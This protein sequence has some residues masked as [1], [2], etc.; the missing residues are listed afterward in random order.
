MGLFSFFNFHTFLSLHILFGL[1]SPLNWDLL[2]IGGKR[3]NGVFLG[4]V[5]GSNYIYKWNNKCTRPRLANTKIFQ[6]CITKLYCRIAKEFGEPQPLSP[7][8]TVG[9]TKFGDV[10]LEFCD[11]LNSLVILC[12]HLKTSKAL[13]K[14]HLNW[15]TLTITL[16]Y[17]GST[18]TIRDI[19]RKITK[20]FNPISKCHLPQLQ[21]SNTSTH[22]NGDFNHFWPWVLTVSQL[23]IL[24]K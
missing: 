12:E 2:N 18:S 24:K 6:R 21:H 13:P 11:K 3:S 16:G 20:V 1:W 9:R 10:K 17:M 22:S 14:M 7:N 15:P 4:N 8:L 5:L 19:V 23:P